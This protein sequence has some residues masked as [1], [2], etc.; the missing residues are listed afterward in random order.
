M[1]ALLIMHGNISDTAK[2]DIIELI[3]DSFCM[4]SHQNCVRWIMQWILIELLRYHDSFLEV[5]NAKI[6]DTGRTHKSTITSFIPV[7]YHLCREK[8][9]A[10]MKDVINVMLA[11]TM[12]AH[13]KLRL[14][15]QVS[16]VSKKH[17]VVSKERVFY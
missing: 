17:N 4:E 8:D 7:L 14:Y 10:I 13:F 15:S 11:W 6:D 16:G 12:G 5:I 2:S 9:L 1:Q 3:T